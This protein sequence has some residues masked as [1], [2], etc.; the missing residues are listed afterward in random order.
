M[1]TLRPGG[2][3]ERPGGD[4]WPRVRG[5]RPCRVEAERRVVVIC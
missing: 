5:P 2:G 4:L 3:K 1:H